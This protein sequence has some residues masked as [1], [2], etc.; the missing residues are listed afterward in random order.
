M[1]DGRRIFVAVDIG[2]DVRRALA[3]HLGAATGTSNLPGKA[4]PAANWHL[5]LRF[6]GMVGAVAYDRLLAGLD[7]APLGPSFPIR[8][9]RL[10]AFPRPGR[11]TVLWMG[12]DEGAEDLTGLAETVED[13]VAGAGLPPEDRPFHPHLTLSRIRPQQDVRPL[14]ERVPPFARRQTVP[15]ITV[16]ESRLGGGPAVYR[17]LESFPLSPA[18]S[19]QP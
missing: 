8:F 7:Q 5:T 11:A 12:I 15:A 18:S 16:F 17:P 9:G 19:L 3:A 13:V 10:G 6:L 14:L 4:V 2:D 1:T